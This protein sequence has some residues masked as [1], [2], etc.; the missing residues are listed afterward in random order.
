MGVPIYT[1]PRTRPASTPAR[2]SP[3]TPQRRQRR[4]AI[5][6]GA[7]FKL[8]GVEGTLPDIDKFVRY[9]DEQIA[10]SVL[11]TC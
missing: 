10:R 3:P 2:R 11:A 7:T 9:Q 4:R 1:A 6:N 5:P 8:K